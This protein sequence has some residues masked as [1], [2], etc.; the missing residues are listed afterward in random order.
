MMSGTCY[1]FFISKWM[2]SLTA[3]LKFLKTSLIIET[4]NRAFITL[5]QC[6]LLYSKNKKCPIMI[7][8]WDLTIKNVC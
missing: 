8:S 2:K 5:T 3:I 1:I 7:M 6:K 4:G